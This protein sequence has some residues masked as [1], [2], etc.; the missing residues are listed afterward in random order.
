[1]MTFP[2]YGKIKHVPVTTNQKRL[3]QN[4]QSYWTKRERIISMRLENAHSGHPLVTR[5]I[6]MELQRVLIRKM[7]QIWDKH[8]FGYFLAL[9]NAY[10]LGPIITE[11]CCERM[12][13]AHP[14]SLWSRSNHN[15]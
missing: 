3:Q 13:A 5:H 4:Y 14:S 11:H 2:I 6:D 7:I 12:G 9:V 8:I 10:F 1:M 15:N